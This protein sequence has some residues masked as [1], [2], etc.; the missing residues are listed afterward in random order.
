M[1]YST[2]NRGRLCCDNCGTAGGVR[3]RKCPHTVTTD[4]ARSVD[5]RRHVLSYCPAPAVCAACWAQ[6]G[7]NAG[8]H[9][10]CA[11]GAAASQ[12]DYDRTQ[13]RLD[14]GHVMVM[15]AAGSWHD[16]VPEGWVM[17]TGSDERAYLL[18]AD[19]YGNRGG[20]VDDYPRAQ[21]LEEVAA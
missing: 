12:A 8:V 18:P 16:D 5:G 3:R 9:G 7:G 11:E 10:G 6:L 21:L 1:G 20:F 2:D 13:A 17:L 15:S 14:A 19:D 4:N